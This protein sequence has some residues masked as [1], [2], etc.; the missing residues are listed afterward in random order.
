MNFK[1]LNTFFWFKLAQFPMKGQLRSRLI[2]WGGVDI[3]DINRTFIG[4]NFVFDTLYPENIHVG[5]HVHITAGVTILTH[6][7]ETEKNGI[8]WRQGDV[9][10][11]DNVF[12]GTG[13]II[14]KDVKIGNNSIIGAGSV[15]TKDIPENEIW[16]GNPA[17]YIKKRIN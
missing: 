8:N 16:A 15:V 3:E 1:R 13:T 6:Y 11:G 17:R 4:K 9:Y 5:K 12:I 14:S 7:L 10:I 2:R